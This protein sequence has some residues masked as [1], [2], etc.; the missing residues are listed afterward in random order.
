MAVSTPYVYV[1]GQVLDVDGH[2]GNIYSDIPGQGIISEINGGLD[3]Y[4]TGYK[5]QKE[6]V[7]P[8]EASRVRKESAI[9]PLDVFSDAFCDN[10]SNYYR[11][12]AGCSARVY[13]P[14]SAT[15]CLW[16]WSI[17]IHSF[18]PLHSHVV[19]D[20]QTKSVT[21]VDSEMYI[22][23]SL[24]GSRLTHTRR[25]IPFTAVVERFNDGTT[26]YDL[27]CTE[28]RCALQFDMSHL[29]ENPSAGW[30]DISLQMYME[31]LLETDGSGLLTER[32]HRA[33]AGETVHNIYSRLSF[34]IRSARVLTLI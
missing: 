33:I 1:D 14:Y 9:E 8:E 28:A 23:A 21:N 13:L 11:N 22:R 6:H 30:H 2:N 7:W 10:D 29:Q 27:S 31:P 4:A 12:V 18:R 20:G 24:N 34:G 25:R 19:N 16:Q 26:T 5:I 3:N 15:L 17:F 32:V